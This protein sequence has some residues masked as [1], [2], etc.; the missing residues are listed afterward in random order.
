MSLSQVQTASTQAAGK[1]RT[2]TRDDFLDAMK[3]RLKGKEHSSFPIVQ[4]IAKGTATREQIGFLA[5]VFYHFTKVT[6]QVLSSIHARC[7]DRRI[8]RAIMD[9]LIDEDTELRCGSKGHD[10]LAMDFATRFTGWSEADVEIFDR[11]QWLRDMVD[12]RFKVARELPIPIALGNSGIASE[13]HA[14]EMCRLI[15][16]GLRDHYGVKDEDQESWIVHIDGD[17]DHSDTAFKV[18]LDN[19]QTAELQ[20]QMFWCIDEYTRHWANFWRACEAGAVDIRKN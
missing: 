12:Y 8:R 15:S 2:L 4:A 13:S 10:A 3:S 19:C 18:V 16:D 7:E 9:T 14:P 6:P 11:P 20:Q 17:E 1:S 5:V